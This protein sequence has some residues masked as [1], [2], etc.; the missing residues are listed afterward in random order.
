MRDIGQDSQHDSELIFRNL[1]GGVVYRQGFDTHIGITFVI[2]FD[3]FRK[4]LKD[5]SFVDTIKLPGIIIHAV[6]F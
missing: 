1:L 5:F 2:Q 6:S 3:L 4:G